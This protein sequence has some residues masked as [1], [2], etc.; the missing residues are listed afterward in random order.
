MLL[1]TQTT[2]QKKPAIKQVA[3]LDWPAY[4]R[5]SK[6]RGTSCYHVMQGFYSANPG[7]NHHSLTRGTG[8][9]AG[10]QGCFHGVLYGLLPG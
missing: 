3:S 9:N 4:G 2:R 5:G 1:I 6:G 8:Y 10:S 7:H